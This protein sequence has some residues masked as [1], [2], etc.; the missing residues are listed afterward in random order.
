MDKREVKEIIIKQNIV[1][2]N[3]VCKLIDQL[4]DL[5]ENS[6]NFHG[7]G[8]WEKFID[9][10]I[11]SIYNDDTGKFNLYAPVEKVEEYITKNS[12]AQQDR[13]TIPAF[14]G[15]WIEKHKEPI[16]YSEDYY[17]SYD[18]AEREALANS[19][20][21]TIYCLFGNF[22]DTNDD[23]E[24]RRPINSWLHEDRC[25][26]FKLVDAV[27]YGYEVEQEPLYTVTYKNGDRLLKMK[28]GRLTYLEPDE[29]PHTTFS[30]GWTLELTRSEIESV[31]PILMEIAKEVE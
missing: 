13:V 3:E 19:I 16:E 20:H 6:K 28:D 7:D 30:H 2:V 17:D 14:V 22:P 26:Y 23:V 24:L 25:N 27:R 21:F 9:R 8:N 29:N 4:D 10:H 11:I 12:N 5:T 31:D 1:G 15:E 18:E